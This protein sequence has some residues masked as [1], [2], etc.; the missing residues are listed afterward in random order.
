MGTEHLAASDEVST[1]TLSDLADLR[2]IAPPLRANPDR[3]ASVRHAVEQG[4]RLAALEGDEVAGYAVF[5]ARF[6]GPA[7]AELPIA[8][9][10]HRRPGIGT[11][12]P[13]EAENRRSRKNLFTSSDG[14]GLSARL[15]IETC[16]L[17]RR[18]Q[19]L[20]RNEGDPELG[21]FRAVTSTPAPR[22][23]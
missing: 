15:L 3:A 19:L 23:S 11:L 21:Y 22:S 2:L 20:E 12:L 18:G 9:P 16:G 5:N 14:S 1:A 8:W 4:G 17:P 10:A 6:F 13:S 7:F